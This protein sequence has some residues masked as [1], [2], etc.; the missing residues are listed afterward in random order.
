M[1]LRFRST[2]IFVNQYCDC[3]SQK[4]I[5]LKCNVMLLSLVYFLSLHFWCYYDMMFLVGNNHSFC[6]LLLRSLIQENGFGR[7]VQCAAILGTFVFRIKQY[8][9]IT[10]Q[11]ICFCENCVSAQSF[12]QRRSYIFA[13][14]GH[15]HQNLGNWWQQ[16]DSE[17]IQLVF[18]FRIKAMNDTHH[19]FSIMSLFPL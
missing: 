1:I 3:W 7:K 12:W 6:L 17:T 4:R 15:N 13:S 10:Y 9:Y 14:K 16:I 19:S 18:W 11:F 2:T 8:T 5:A